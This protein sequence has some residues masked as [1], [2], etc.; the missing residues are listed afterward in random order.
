MLWFESIELLND[1][2]DKDVKYMDLLVAI[3]NG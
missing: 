1:F 3:N 2:I